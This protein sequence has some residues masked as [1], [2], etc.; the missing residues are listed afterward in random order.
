MNTTTTNPTEEVTTMSTTT[1]P[2]SVHPLTTIVDR[3]EYDDFRAFAMYD[4]IRA[5]PNSRSNHHDLTV[6]DIEV[7]NRLSGVVV[8]VATQD[9]ETYLH[10]VSVVTR[11]VAE[12][13]YSV[14][15]RQ[16]GWTVEFTITVAS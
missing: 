2:T 6:A 9:M 11:E 12:N 14:E 10:I 3:D 13:G 5:Y 15:I 4:L 7:Y 8:E 16:H 1:N